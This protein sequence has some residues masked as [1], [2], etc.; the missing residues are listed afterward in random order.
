MTEDSY[1]YGAH[2]QKTEWRGFE[3][4]NSGR[5]FADVAPSQRATPQRQGH[6]DAQHFPARVV[7]AATR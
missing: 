3:K 4:P 1:A 6:G 2:G 5:K 7:Y